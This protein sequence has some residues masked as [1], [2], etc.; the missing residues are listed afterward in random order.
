MKKIEKEPSTL[1]Q[2]KT[3]LFSTPSTEIFIDP[4]IYSKIMFWVQKATGEV[5]GLGK[6]QFIED[7]IV[8]TDAILIEQENGASSTELDADA[9]TKAMYEMRDIPGHLNFWWHS[10]VDMAVFWSGTDHQT[11]QQL[12]GAG[13]VLATVFNKREQMR[14]AI[15]QKGN[16]FFPPVF[17][18]DI[19]TK[20]HSTI[21]QADQEQ[22]EK[23][24][25]E[26]CKP[27]IF[28]YKNYGKASKV[29]NNETFKEFFTEAEKIEIVKKFYGYGP[30]LAYTLDEMWED[31]L[32]EG[33]A[34]DH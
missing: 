19:P 14:S 17:L 20:V 6:V 21:S 31:Y 12:G 13:W 33:R 26:K 23:E 5:S 15:Y 27:I 2:S 9:V 7:K 1:N 34:Y 18:D 30:T 8:V 22:W 25:D 4:K 24:F 29:G 10:H 11:I 28:K 16:G 3:F 32:W